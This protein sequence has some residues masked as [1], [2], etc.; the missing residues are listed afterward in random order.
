M[1]DLACRPA[2]VWWWSIESDIA[3]E[4]TY[5]FD[6]MRFIALHA[7]RS[8][9]MSTA[10]NAVDWLQTGHFS[11]LVGAG[12]GAARSEFPVASGGIG[13][14]PGHALGEVVCPVVL[15][16]PNPLGV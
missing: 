2:I 1:L 15:P 10:L 5:V 16:V 14:G 11:H 6:S 8:T 3:A 13:H 9:G 4:R 12:T 7:N